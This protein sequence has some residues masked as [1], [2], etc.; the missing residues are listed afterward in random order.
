MSHALMDERPVLTGER[1]CRGQFDGEVVVGLFSET[2]SLR[3]RWD[4]FARGRGAE[5]GRAG[6]VVAIPCPRIVHPFWIDMSKYLN[7]VQSGQR[8]LTFHEHAIRPGELRSAPF[9]R[10]VAASGVVLVY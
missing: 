6:G 7:R 8:F 3:W 5:H 4:V 10:P 9:V 2:G 1:A